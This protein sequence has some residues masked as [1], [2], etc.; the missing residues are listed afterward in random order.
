MELLGESSGEQTEKVHPEAAPLSG[1]VCFRS[2]MELIARH[3]YRCALTGRALTPADASLDHVIPISR[4]GPDRIENAQLVHRAVNRAKGALTNEE[5]VQL[6]REVVA[7]SE[8]SVL[9]KS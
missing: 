8:A 1:P 9:R 2:V 3:Q 5:F 6:C 4:G 7:W